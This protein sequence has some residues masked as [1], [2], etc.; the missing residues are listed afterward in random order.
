MLPCRALW[1]CRFWVTERR[2]YQERLQEEQKAA[3]DTSDLATKVAEQANAIRAAKGR[4]LALRSQVRNS[5]HK[6]RHSLVVVAFQLAVFA[7]SSPP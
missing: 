2:V 6:C 1:C 4:I 5:A 3:A 7:R